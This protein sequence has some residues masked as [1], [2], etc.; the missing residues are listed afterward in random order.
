[1]FVF[2]LIQIDT[3]SFSEDCVTK[4]DNIIAQRARENEKQGKKK[5]TVLVTTEAKE[6]EKKNSDSKERRSILKS[7][8]GKHVN[9][10]DSSILLKETEECQT[11]IPLV[12][13]KVD[14]SKQKPNDSNSEEKEKAPM[15]KMK[16]PETEEK[17]ESEV[18]NI[19]G[20]ESD[21][22]ESSVDYEDTEDNET[23][24]EE[25][26]EEE[27]IETTEATKAESSTGMSSTSEAGPTK[28]VVASDV[29]NNNSAGGD[30]S[31]DSHDSEG[32]VTK[33][34]PIKKTSCLST[35]D[36]II[37]VVSEF[38]SAPNA[39][40]I[41]DDKI[42]LL[43]VEYSFLDI[44]ADEL[45]T[46]FSLPKPNAQERITFNFRKV[47][48]VDRT[49]NPSRRRLLSKMLRSEDDNSRLLRFKVVTE[50]P[51][52]EPDLDCEDIG[53]A[54]IDLGIIERT[55]KDL[56]EQSLDVFS[57]KNQEI[58]IGTLIVSIEAAQAFKS[59]KS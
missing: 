25:D 53:V 55:G 3:V 43:Y 58:C 27:D 29:H 51:D 9:S 44:P 35:K 30:L 20:E 52:S 40:F 45:E 10:G 42:S 19:D 11:K 5:K 21:S 15:V 50:P 23:D 12:T 59:I 54:D 24:D 47:F 28:T 41:T 33:T 8:S 4:L 18:E 1:M 36:N 7:F 2:F 6:I 22:Y 26:E 56:L 34:S 48:K 17:K 37:I 46:P 16:D 57:I 31:N 14:N 32:V 38:E 39:D 49:N 13:T